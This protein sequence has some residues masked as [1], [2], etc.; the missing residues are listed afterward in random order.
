MLFIIASVMQPVWCSTVSLVAH[1]SDGMQLEQA[2]IGKPFLIEVIVD[3]AGHTIEPPRW[4]HAADIHLHSSGYHLKTLNGV[5]QATYQFRARIDKPGIYT[6]GPAII[7]SASSNVISVT[8][9]EQ[10]KVRGRKAGQAKGDN[11]AFLRFSLNKEK[12]VV[13]QRLKGTLRFYSI[14][15]VNVSLLEPNPQECADITFKR[16]SEPTTGMQTI[17]DIEYNYAQWLFDIY[18]QRACRCVIPAFAAEYSLPIPQASFFNPFGF[19]NAIGSRKR[20]YSNGLSF[21]V[22][23]LPSSKVPVNVVGQFFYFESSIDRTSAR[24]GDGLVLQLTLAGDGDLK[25]IKPPVL[26]ALPAQIKWY[27]SNQTVIPDQHHP[28]VEKKIFE[29][30]IQP[31]DSGTFTIPAQHFTYYDVEEKKIKTINSQPITL[32]IIGA[33]AT[34]PI[35]QEKEEKELL[36]EVAPRDTKLE[37]APLVL[38]LN[39]SQPWPVIPLPWFI[40]LI[41]IMLGLLC[42]QCFIVVRSSL[43]AS[44]LPSTKRLFADAYK[45]V[46]AAYEHKDYAMIYAAFI[47]LFA[48]YTNRPI[49]QISPEDIQKILKEKNASEEVI[50]QW[51]QF[52]EQLAENVY[53]DAHQVSLRYPDLGSHA[54][55]W[56]E[57]LKEIL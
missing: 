14:E 53:Y 30:I 27:E 9:G 22:T 38:S 8:V 4:Q 48:H 54:L 45:Q 43:V 24:V 12:A 1:A 15:P 37:L 56:L 47:T 42:F 10:E 13:G 44:R 3:Q 46:R 35:A 34:A 23:A 50:A 36:E 17:D 2:G 52:F 28:N 16:N 39:A 20:I 41:I 57:T 55:A 11:R 40:L 19:I 49:T 33:S 21:D 29:Y 7:G 31:R 6:I 25:V 32:T 26:T 5:T 51:K 18:P